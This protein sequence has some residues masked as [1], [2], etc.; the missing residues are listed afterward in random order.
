MGRLANTTP[1]RPAD[2]RHTPLLLVIATDWTMRRMFQGLLQD[3]GHQ[4]ITARSGGEAVTLYE[5]H[6]PDL[7]LLDLGAPA[8]DAFATCAALRALAGN[9]P[10]P[11]LT[12]ADRDSADTVERAFRAGAS[13]F[14]AKPVHPTLLRER[15]RQALHHRAT[16]L[17]LAQAQARLADFQPPPPAAGRRPGSMLD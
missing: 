7:V 6:Q 2:R 11:L 5:Q 12:L 9:S 15:I 3:L 16:E 4:V 8:P 17:A 14:Q 1:E 10:L 13:D